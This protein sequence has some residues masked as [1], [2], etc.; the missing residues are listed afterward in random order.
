MD[1]EISFRPEGYFDISK[2]AFKERTLETYIKMVFRDS[3]LRWLTNK[4]RRLTSN[5]PGIWDHTIKHYSPRKNEP[6]PTSKRD[7]N[8]NFDWD[9]K[10]ENVF[11]GM[12]GFFEVGVRILD[13]GS[14]MGQITEQINI[15]YRGRVE[16]VGIDYRYLT[17]ERPERARLVGGEFRNLP[18][19]SEKF[20]RIL[21]VESFPAWLPRK[22]NIGKYFKEITRVS[23]L[24]TIWRGTLPI[25]RHVPYE[26]P[27]NDFELIGFFLE[28]GWEVVLDLS[29]CAFFAR[30]IEKNLE[31]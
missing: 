22:E 29:S 8:I 13:L 30:L 10:E 31:S 17:E 14:G 24:G 2:A 18:F 9:W 23:K 6:S 7:P 12:D 20:D 4:P 26:L 11:G 28:N 1:N 5:D 3:T 27:I 19:A 21:S 25:E 15:R 16:C